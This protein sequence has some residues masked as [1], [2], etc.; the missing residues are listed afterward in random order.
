MQIQNASHSFAKTKGSG[1]QTFTATVTFPSTLTKATAILTGFVA[2]FSPND[3]HHLGQLD[4][5]VSV[6]SGGV[7]GNSV[8]VN[9]ELGVRDWSGNW[10]DYYQ[11]KVLFS[12]I[13]E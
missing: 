3:D 4:V 10:D 5:Q 6:P 7:K 8:S 12:V 2:E 1:P 9:I 13:G 11:G